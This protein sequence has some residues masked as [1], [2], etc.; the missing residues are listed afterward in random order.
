MT[1]YKRYE[2]CTSCVSLMY[3]L[4]YINRAWENTGSLYN[5]RVNK[6]MG[7]FENTAKNYSFAAR[8]SIREI[9]EV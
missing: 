5:G 2:I 4:D 3:A 9:W 6:L 7:D 1:M 8:Y